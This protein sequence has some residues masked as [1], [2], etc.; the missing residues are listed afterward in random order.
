M[1]LTSKPIQFIT[2]AGKLAHWV[3]AKTVVRA[4]TG[5]TL[6]INGCGRT[7]IQSG[8]AS[9]L[10]HSLTKVLFA[11]PDATVVW[12]GHD[13]QGHTKSTNGQE[14]ASN[15]RVAGKSEAEFVA[16]MEALK[17]PK[18]QRIDEA[19]PANLRSGLRHDADAALDWAVR[20]QA[21]DAGDVS[22]DLAWQWVSNGKAVLV[23]VRSAVDAAV[24]ATVVCHGDKSKRL[25]KRDNPEHRITII[26][27]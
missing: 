2:S 12:P 1:P 5:D 13:Y 3:G 6:L 21:T 7:D 26:P 10:S 20:P 17:L 11:W 27:R 22:P 25:G 18:P 14:K 19:V 15:I 16:T 23:D 8:S 4:F 24:G 9:A